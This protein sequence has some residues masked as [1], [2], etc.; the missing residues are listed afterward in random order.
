MTSGVA[1]AVHDSWHLGEAPAS[2][3]P[4]RR[5]RPSTHKIALSVRV[6]QSNPIH[7]WVHLTRAEAT[8]AETKHFSEGGT[9]ISEGRAGK[10]ELAA[11]V[12]DKVAWQNER[13]LVLEAGKWA[14][15]NEVNE[16]KRALDDMQAREIDLAAAKGE[17][18][19][20]KGELA[21][22]KEAGERRRSEE[23]IE[24]D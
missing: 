19:A 15:E 13:V 21:E 3:R 23:S 11:A 9:G 18:D 12:T 5:C 17:V 16:L 6:L 22:H 8:L 14:V 1:R 10:G 2:Q 20:V 4:P 24:G 7:S